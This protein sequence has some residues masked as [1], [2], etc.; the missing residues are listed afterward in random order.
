MKAIRIDILDK[1]YQ[2]EDRVY[3][4]IT[5]F[6]LQIKQHEFVCLVGASGCGKTTL[7]NIVAG[8]DKH[9]H[10]S[11]AWSTGEKLSHIGYVFQNPRLLRILQNFRRK[12][13]D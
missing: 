5:D 2:S 9:F 8:L 12:W 1:T 6:Q 4:T 13:I 3:T 11:I 7:L 10:G